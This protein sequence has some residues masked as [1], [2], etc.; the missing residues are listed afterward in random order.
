[1]VEYYAS[2]IEWMPCQLGTAGRWGGL[3]PVNLDKC[4]PFKSGWQWHN[5][6]FSIVLPKNLG[7]QIRGSHLF[8]PKCIL[9]SDHPKGAPYLYQVKEKTHF[10]L[11]LIESKLVPRPLFAS[12]LTDDDKH[13]FREKSHPPPRPSNSCVWRKGFSHYICASFTSHRDLKPF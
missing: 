8:T 4:S 10:F 5:Q 2:I 6:P 3:L 7:H 13:W 1:M 11:F 9:M 12:V